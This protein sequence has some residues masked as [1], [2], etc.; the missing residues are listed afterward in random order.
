MCN[1]IFR[2]WAYLIEWYLA[3][4][5]GWHSHKSVDFHEFEMARHK[6]D[7]YLAVFIIVRTLVRIQ[8]STPEHMK[9]E[10]DGA[11]MISHLF[12]QCSYIYQTSCNDMV[13]E[14]CRSNYCLLSP[15]QSSI[16][17]MIVSVTT[18]S[19]WNSFLYMSCNHVF[20]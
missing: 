3:D 16:H 20:F 13:D 15:T 8:S 11:C 19:F 1:V 10:C 5:K 18:N 12:L 4:F 9:S 17:P 7:S 14:I 2:S 6:H